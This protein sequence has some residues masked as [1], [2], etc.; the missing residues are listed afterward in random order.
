MSSDDN[1]ARVLEIVGRVDHT[2]TRV[3]A[4]WLAGTEG[5]EAGSPQTLADLAA[6]T[7]RVAPST[8]VDGHLMWRGAALEQLREEAEAGTPP[9][10]LEQARMVL[11][12]RC[13]NALMLVSRQ[14]DEPR[15]RLTGLANRS[16]LIERMEHALKGAARYGDSVGVIF[17]E[18]QLPETANDVVVEAAERLRR[19]AR[20][21]DTIARLGGSE[22]V[23]VCERLRGEL[24]AVAIADRA[25]LAL[26]QAYTVNGEMVYVGVTEGIAVSSGG[27]GPE[28]LLADASAARRAV[29]EH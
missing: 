20:S 21:S 17:I 18:L 13:D 1:A 22:F 5:P 10:L 23:I 14:F 12:D 25:R 15:D 29:A 19:V 11:T 26:S 3:V 16:L 24:E 2:A 7:G 8:L 6:L 9:E 4:G 28:T 27:E